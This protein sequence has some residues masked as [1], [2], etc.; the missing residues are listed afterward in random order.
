[1]SMRILIVAVAG[2]P[3]LASD[4]ARAKP[5]C[6]DG[7]RMCMSACA[8]D[9]SPERCM[10]RCQEAASRCEKSGVFRM[11]VGFLINKARLEELSRAQGVPPPDLE[12]K[13]TRVRRN[14][15]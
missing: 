8:V 2:F 3:L 10:Q 12:I 5:E 1:M 14:L 9:K 4:A 6:E 11:L 13:A 15:R 7:Y